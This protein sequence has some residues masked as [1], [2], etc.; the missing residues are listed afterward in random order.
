MAGLSAPLLRDS[1]LKPIWEK[2]QR[3][4]RLSFDDGLAMLQTPDVPGLGQMADWF[5][6]EKNG[7]RVMF[8]I[9]RQLNPTNICVLSCKFCEFAAKRR[10]PY[11]YEM[12]IDECLAVLSD[13][14]QEVHIVGGL[15][16]DWP[17]KYYL[18]LISAIRTRFRR[19]T[20]KA[21]T[22]VEIDYFA[23]KFRKSHR[24][25][26]E[27]MVQA[28]LDTLPGGGA[29]VFSE[30]I[31]KELFAQKI[32]YREWR[33]IHTL[34][35]SLGVRS[36]ATMLYGH[37]ETFAERVDHMLKVREMHDETGGFYAFIPLAFQPG[38]TGIKPLRAS[39][40]DDLR[41]VAASRLLIDNIPHIKAYWV[42]LGEETASV[43]LNFG[44]SDMDGTIGEEKIAH[45]ALASSPVGITRD[46]I[47]KL[48]HEAGKVPAER[49]A[50]YNVLKVYTGNGTKSYGPAWAAAGAG[51][52]A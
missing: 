43:A 16:P 47:L 1:S 29:E 46:R 36:N 3:G 22:A 18:D 21:W 9:N 5:N 31:Q 28:G 50:R 27:E 14:M 17:W 26:L 40:V 52:G 44:A 12:T 10:S 20:I 41:T 51:A 2:I 39:A 37:I 35:H 42:M 23:R 4:E 15:H 7:D 32:G 19:M 49:D 48:I 8:V 34:A 13:E 6:Q 30:R 38:M 45:A 25:V 33:K 24:E 11:A